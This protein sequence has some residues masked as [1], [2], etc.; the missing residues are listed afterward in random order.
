MTVAKYKPNFSETRHA[1]YQDG[2]LNH[3]NVIN[4]YEL[5]NKF[6]LDSN[7]SPYNQDDVE[8]LKDLLFESKF[9][10]VQLGYAI[11]VISWCKNKK[12]GIELISNYIR[13]LS[14]ISILHMNDFWMLLFVKRNKV[15]IEKLL[16]GA[17]SDIR[18]ALVNAVLF[19][20]PN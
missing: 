17:E 16:K 12:V 4:Y 9:K 5:I 6:V 20:T 11:W 3:N 14:N 10:T 1:V 13:Y 15:F 18:L 2:F 19:L 8:L 7:L